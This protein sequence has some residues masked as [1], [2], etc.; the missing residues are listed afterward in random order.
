LSDSLGLKFAIGASADA[1]E[2]TV[3]SDGI[4]TIVKSLDRL[5]K[6]E[7]AGN[8]RSILPKSYAKELTTVNDQINTVAKSLDSLAK[9]K[10]GVT[11][12]SSTRIGP[13]PLSVG[14]RDRAARN[15]ESIAHAQER[16]W[17]RT[18]RAFARHRDRMERAAERLAERQARIAQRAADKANAPANFSAMR[19]G[20]E[21]AGRLVQPGQD[22]LATMVRSAYTTEEAMQDV[23]KSLKPDEFK[24]F[25]RTIR[26]TANAL[27]HELNVPLAETIKGI[28]VLARANITPATA[29]FANLAKHGLALAVVEGQKF[30]NI[31][32]TLIQITNR[33]T[34][35]SA[36]LPMIADKLTAASLISTTGVTGLREGLKMAAPVM[37]K[38]KVDINEQIA[39]VAIM[40]DQLLR[41]TMGGTALSRMF[42]GL[43]SQTLRSKD[44]LK[45]LSFAAGGKEKVQL[46]DAQGNLRPISQVVARIG[47]LYK[48]ANARSPGAGTAIVDALF[49]ARG[50]QGHAA[51]MEVL[52]TAPEKLQQ[53]MAEIGKS[54]GMAVQQAVA[55]SDNIAGAVQRLKNSTEILATTLLQSFSG[56]GSTLLGGLADT[57]VQLA[58]TYSGIYNR[59][60]SP[61]AAA[62]KTEFGVSAISKAESLRGLINGIEAGLTTLLAP[63]RFVGDL[64]S[65]IV[66]NKAGL[67]F[68][69]FLGTAVAGLTGLG[70]VI[71][72][73]GVAFRGLQGAALFLQT[74]M[75]AAARAAV[76]NAA[77]NST[78]STGSAL[79]SFSAAGAGLLSFALRG[80]AI[81]A[82]LALA[83]DIFK[84]S[85]GDM[86][87]IVNDMGGLAKVRKQSIEAGVEE[88]RI[89]LS[90]GFSP[91]APPGRDALPPTASQSLTPDYIKQEF[92][93]LADQTRNTPLSR[94]DA[95]Q[96]KAPLSKVWAGLG[97]EALGL[98]QKGGPLDFWGDALGSIPMV[99]K[100]RGIRPDADVVGGSA[101][102]LLVER[103]DASMESTARAALEQGRKQE[104][105]MVQLMKMITTLF[106]GK[107]SEDMERAMRQAMQDLLDKI[108]GIKGTAT[109]DTGKIRIALQMDA[110]NASQRA[111]RGKNQYQSYASTRLGIA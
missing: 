89:R 18:E 21:Q 74:G 15:A 53:F 111:Q 63:L 57:V 32:E 88:A 83:V 43:T 3:V 68:L 81:L 71:G 16:A 31:A 12:E 48:M 40:N 109:A 36:A 103:I 6:S 25:E 72:I 90:K 56:R 59:G 101:M 79:A 91:Y 70:L 64:F 35:S 19:Y 9:K 8:Q 10:A 58:N 7:R 75:T 52:E 33:L 94:A 104:E 20:F 102:S 69:G 51:L 95:E 14:E 67:A 46:W 93:P 100:A 22:A 29:N 23:Q 50:G 105:V 4:A 92:S 97:K 26:D 49:G 45:V 47:E 77:A 37:R 98:A 85:A 5:A 73:V 55:K 96:K 41:G 62:T 28:G 84:T 38:H 24:K 106:G 99:L 44:M 54:S 17:D 2:L 39:L 82:P 11:G 80:V 42:Q 108:K 60:M 13:N 66:G 78:A 110:D 86:R 87:E 1:S 76:A 30:E 65:S 107:L 34:G 27:S 61:D